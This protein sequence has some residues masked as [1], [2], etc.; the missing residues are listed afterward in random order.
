[1]QAMPVRSQRQSDARIRTLCRRGVLR[2]V[3]ATPPVSVDRAFLRR[4]ARR[5][6]NVE[7]HYHGAAKKFVLYTRAA[8]SGRSDADLLVKELVFGENGTPPVPG[9][10]LIGWMEWTD[11]YAGGAI[12]PAQAR[13]NYLT[14]LEEHE[15][16]RLEHWDKQR[17]QMSEEVAKHLGW[18]IDSRIS[19]SGGWEKPRHPNKKARGL[20]P[21]AAC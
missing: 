19:F 1:M 16:K 12:N 3:T 2:T 17:Y 18:C 11:K 6:P 15:R 10:W 9:D 20:K 4:L 13:N 7:L 5:D 21:V 14:G 8:G